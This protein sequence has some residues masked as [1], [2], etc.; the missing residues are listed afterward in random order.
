MITC[1]ED[2]NDKLKK[3][4]KNYKMLT[5]ILK[6]HDTIFIIATSSSSII[7]SVTGIGLI[8]LPIS[9]SKTCGISIGNKVMYEIVMQNYFKYKKQ[10]QKINKLVNLLIIYTAKITTKSF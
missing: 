6:S 3:N 8:A 7:L 9:T 2:K 5:T 10:Y 1:F 4:C